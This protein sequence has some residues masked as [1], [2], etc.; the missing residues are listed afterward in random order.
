[1]LPHTIQYMRTLLPEAGISRRDTYLHPT[2]NCEMKLLIPAWDTCFW[3]QSPHISHKVFTQFCSCNELRQSCEGPACLTASLIY[4]NRDISIFDYNSTGRVPPGIQAIPSSWRWHR[5][6]ERCPKSAVW[7]KDLYYTG[8][9]SLLRGYGS[10]RR[11]GRQ[12]DGE[13]HWHVR[14]TFALWKQV[15]NDWRYQ[16]LWLTLY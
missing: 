10:Y 11:N 16:H 13:A 7:A 5:H 8:H 4:L 1:M 6:S 15:L 9:I 2:V 14:E 12:N 3:L